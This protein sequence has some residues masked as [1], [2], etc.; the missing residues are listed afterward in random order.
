VG[1]EEIY[2]WIK[3]NEE[4]FTAGQPTA[5]QLR[6]LAAEGFVTVI[7]LATYDPEYALADEESLVRSLDMSYHHIPVAWEAPQARDYD[8]FE[9]LMIQRPEGKTLIHCV[10]NYRA[11]AFYGLY[12]Q[13]HLGWNAAQA[14][15]FRA[16]I[17][18]G[19][20]YPVWENFVR[21]MRRHTR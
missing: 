15:A 3:V 7:N 2:H 20:D 10:A 4:I 16:Q 9:R 19:A 6:S 18:S 1:S 17:W 21:E 14:D 5:G 11:T 13:K 12:A 8:A